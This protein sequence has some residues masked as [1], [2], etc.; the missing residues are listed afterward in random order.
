MYAILAYINALVT[1]YKVQ[2]GRATIGC[3]NK[4]S[5]EK[6]ETKDRRIRPVVKH[7]DVIRAIQFFRH[8]IPTA[9]RLTFVHVRGHQDKTVHFRDLPRIAQLNVQMDTMAKKFLAEQIDTPDK[10]RD[11]YHG[12]QTRMRIGRSTAHTSVGCLLRYSVGFH[13][14]RTSRMNGQLQT[15]EAFDAV[16]L[17]A[18]GESNQA[19]PQL[20]SLFTAK[21]VSGFNA[22]NKMGVH[23]SL[24]DSS[25]CP[26]CKGAVESSAHHSICPHKD[27][28]TLWRHDVTSLIS[29]M[30]KAH[31]SVPLL[32]AL[33]KFLMARGKVSFQYCCPYPEVLAFAKDVDSIS[34]VNITWG[35]LPLAMTRYQDASFRASGSRRSSGLWACGIS[36]ELI[37]LVHSQWSL[38]CN[39][40]HDRGKDGLREKERSTLLQDMEAQFSL[41]RLGL[42]KE[43]QGLFGISWSELWEKS[44][45]EKIGWVEAVKAARMS[46]KPNQQRI[47]RR[48]ST[49]DL[50]SATSHPRRPM[51]PITR[52]KTTHSHKYL[53][54]SAAIFPPNQVMNTKEVQL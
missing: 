7:S 31:T 1:V 17:S 5:L 28:T 37:G 45:M 41:G 23:W 8:N 18:V 20:F 42:D 29:W 26:C 39:F 10:I 54:S 24:A 16:D 48:R 50:T 19:A 38:R 52:S 30:W 44:G 25:S 36:H 21:L 14:Y 3:D 22:T 9:I 35:R 27:R 2:S 46:W 4:V 40:V 6:F 47:P 43:D 53:I 15:V 12:T 33:S 32:Q 51:G 11:H 49:S 13:N 34:F